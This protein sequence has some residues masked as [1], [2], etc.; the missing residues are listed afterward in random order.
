MTSTR[1]K[2][3][4]LEQRD[5]G[6]FTLLT[7]SFTYTSRTQGF[8]LLLPDYSDLRVSQYRTVKRK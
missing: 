4:H 8:K 1:R 6:T 7:P 2:R 5:H 3:V